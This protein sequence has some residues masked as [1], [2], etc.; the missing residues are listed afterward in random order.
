MAE[1]SLV[2]IHGIGNQKK[3]W[4]GNFRTAMKAELGEDASRVLIVDAWWAPLS[5]LKETFRPTLAGTRSSRS[6]SRVA[7][8]DDDTYAR[9][10]RDYA[11]MLAV[12]AGAPPRT[13]TFGPGD[14]IDFIKRKLPQASDIVGDAANYIARN[15]VRTGMQNVLHEALG[16]AGAQDG[17]TPVVL[18]GHS[19]GTIVSYDVLRQAG[20]NYPGVQTWVTMGSPLKKYLGFPMEWGGKQFGVPTDIRW[21]NLFDKKDIVGKELKGAVDWA[22]PKVEDK[23]VDNA[24]NAGGAH[25]HWGNPQVVKAIAAEVRAVLP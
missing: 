23:Q 11:R 19:Q 4:S 15:G 9:A 16:E 25:D 21:L 14:I 18:A 6:R 3:T 20:M 12:D 1:A 17:A 24:R 13:L 8:V 22:K 7:G 5:T 2:I 10:M